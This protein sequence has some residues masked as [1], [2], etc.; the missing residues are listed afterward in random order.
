M[1]EREEL[2]VVSDHVGTPTWAKELA[3]AVWRL[4][5]LPQ[6]HGIY[7]R[8]DAGVASWYDFS[9]AIQQEVLRVGLLERVIAIRSIASDG[10]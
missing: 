5:R 7:S 2:S 1:R 10:F 8:T 4:A 3:Q 9:V 6:L